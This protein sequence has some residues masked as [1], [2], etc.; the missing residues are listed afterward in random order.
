VKF[1]DPLGLRFFL[2]FVSF[3]GV[4]N[5]FCDKFELFAAALLQRPVETGLVA[6]VALASI[7]GYFQKQAILVAIDE[8]LLYFLGV[9]AFFAFFP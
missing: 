4:V 9:S 6:Y 1:K 2:F 5:F 3:A 8:Y 7:N